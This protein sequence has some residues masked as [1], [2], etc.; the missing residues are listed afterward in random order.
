MNVCWINCR[1]PGCSNK[2]NVGSNN[3]ESKPVIFCSELC[4]NSILLLE[5]EKEISKLDCDDP[6][7]IKMLVQNLVN[8]TKQLQIEL[9]SLKK[10]RKK[11]FGLFKDQELRDETYKRD[12]SFDKE[13]DK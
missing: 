12:W 10:I 8:Q 2:L 11:Y 9:D 13:V 6:N 1:N 4:F 5:N 7:Q 3:A